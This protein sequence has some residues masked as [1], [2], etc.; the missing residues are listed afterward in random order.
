MNKGTELFRKAEAAVADDPVLIDRV[1]RARV[2]LDHQWLYDYRR[3]RR[4]AET[5]GIPFDGPED[6]VAFA[7]ELAAFVQAQLG[8]HKDAYLVRVL[9]RL[10]EAPSYQEHFRRL[11]LR[12][13]TK[14]GPLPV[15]FAETDRARI[16]DIDEF[17][18]FIYPT[19]QVVDDP[20]ASNGLAMRVAKFH[21]PSWAVQ[22]R[23]G[24]LEKLGG[25]GR[26]RVYV[27]ARL[28]RQA[29]EGM[30]FEAGVYNNR[31]REHL[32]HLKFPIGKEGMEPERVKANPDAPRPHGT[33]VTDGEYHLYDMGAYTLDDTGFFIWV[34]TTTGDLYVDR[35]LYV[36]EPD[37]PGADVP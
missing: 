30:A 13:T 5:L 8:P 27:V 21:V 4:D 36:R 28:E 23:T 22:A 35:F 24:D 10:I 31:T 7:D 34:G 19:A 18:A 32:S 3:Y 16:I 1:R 2:S 26:Y 12:A 29:E 20:K 9:P 17:K 14:P 11:K 33:P 25:F 37:V 6:P 15:H